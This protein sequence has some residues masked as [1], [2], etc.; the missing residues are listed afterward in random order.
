MSEIKK[1]LEKYGFQFKRQLGQNFITDINLL[2]SIISDSGV[3]E[4]STV[5]EV[6]AGAGTLTRMLADKAHKVISY[7]IDRALL[8]VLSEVLGNVATLL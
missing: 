6:G 8:P 1:I 4:A 3:T 7:E 2:Q 5:I